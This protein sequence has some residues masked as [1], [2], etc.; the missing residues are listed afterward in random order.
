MICIGSEEYV[1]FQQNQHTN[2]MESTA[3]YQ[4]LQLSSQIATLLAFFTRRESLHWKFS[5]LYFASTATHELPKV[6][7]MSTF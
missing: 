2:I 4:I 6:Y 3:K 7:D 1:T 5:L